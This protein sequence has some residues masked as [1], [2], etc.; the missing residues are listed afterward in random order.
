MFPADPLGQA[1][2]PPPGADFSSC[3][4]D[5]HF[6]QEPAPACLP[7]SLLGEAQQP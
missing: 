3:W 7:M 2:S 6:D 1:G 5:G 4:L